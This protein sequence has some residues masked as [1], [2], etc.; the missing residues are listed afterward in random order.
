MFNVLELPY[1]ENREDGF[2]IVGLPY[3]GR[4][5][6]YYIL[7]PKEGYTAGLEA[8]ERKL[9]P[10][11]LLDSIEKLERYDFS[12]SMPKMD[13]S[14]RF[15]LRPY[16]Q[17]LGICDLFNPSVSFILFFLQHLPY[18]Q[19]YKTEFFLPQ[20]DLTGMTK[21][22]L[23]VSDAVHQAKITVNEVGTEAAA[24]TSFTTTRSSQSLSVD[25][26]F[27]FVIMDSENQ[28]PVFMGR[29]VRPKV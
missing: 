19:K 7:L 20:I 21:E 29:V 17:G 6:H 9:T 15:D 11:L 1:Y 18:F 13:I 10:E 24:A 14:E 26:P 27:M 3:R 22:N 8:L 25:R 28:V 5:F 12:F 2:E 23:L 4:K 16:F